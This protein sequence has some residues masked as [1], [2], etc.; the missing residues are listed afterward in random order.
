MAGTIHTEQEYLDY[1]GEHLLHELNML[2]ETAA[3]V[4]QE[5]PRTFMSSVLLESYVVHL[6]TLIEFF[7]FKPKDGYVR[8]ADFFASAGEWRPT[9]TTRLSA[10]LARSSG[11]A[12]HLTWDRKNDTPPDKEWDVTGLRDDIDAVARDFATKALS[13][14]LHPEIRKFLGLPS[15]DKL[16]WLAGNVTYPN[17]AIGV[18]S[19]STATVLKFGGGSGGSSNP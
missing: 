7:Y 14:R 12:N 16:A 1:S 18:A 15:A 3:R 17:V 9:K 5:P 2:W 4:L 13:G 8:A 11:E 10:A 19:F 6:R